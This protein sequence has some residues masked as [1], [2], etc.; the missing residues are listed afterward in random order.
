MQYTLTEEQ[1]MIQQ[2][3]R[4]FAD[5]ELAPAA[6]GHNK[7]SRFPAELVG[8]LAE[9]GFLGMVIPTE[10]GGTGLGNFPLVLV[11]EE[12]NRACA[13]TGITVSV[14]N[15]LASSPIVRFGSEELK[16]KYLPRLATGELLGAYA[17]TEAGSGSDAAALVT[18]AERDGGE[19]ILNGSKMFVTTGKEADVIICMARTD[20]SHKTRGI[21][22][23]VLE[24]EF[25]G[26]RVGKVEDKMGLRASS[27]VEI[28][29]ENCRVPAENMVGVEGSGFK[30]ALD[31]LNGGRIG[32]AAQS[33]GI[34]QACLDASLRYANEREQ[35]GRPLFKF[36][37]IQWKLAEMATDLEA[38]RLLT[39]NA[40]R[41]R[42]EGK[43]MIKEAS[44]AK[45]FASRACNRAAREAV[46]IFGGAGYT[47][48]FPV[49]RYFR[50]ARITELY[51]GTTEIQR[52]VIA[53]ALAEESA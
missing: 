31:T 30:V 16:K 8:K 40:A 39:Y 43:P 12:L 46:Q 48:D 52:L 17:L 37:A 41:L 9:L 36:Q 5:K 15:S 21:T 32:V 7:E 38:A 33:L 51:E 49:E 34:A 26:L 6:A 29:L 4:E 28:L 13:S 10:Y 53:R 44:M 25:D 18:R 2:A 27:T 23:F 45:L 50:D 19:Y 22:A 1:S 24:T 14:H 20:P 3:A 11:L 35:F 47:T 42:D